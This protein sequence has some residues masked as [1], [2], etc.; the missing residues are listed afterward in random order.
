MRYYL[1]TEFN[2]FK[3]RLLSFA[4]V[5]EDNESIYVINP[6]P[7][8]EAHSITPWVREN[9]IPR[10]DQVPSHIVPQYL[11]YERSA[12]AIEDFLKG[13]ESPEIIVDWPDDIK[14]FSELLI[15]GPGTMIDI[16]RLIYR[17][18]RVD[19]YPSEFPDCVQH[20]AWWDAM[21]LKVKCEVDGLEKR[22]TKRP[23]FPANT[24]HHPSSGA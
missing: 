20:N 14:Y 1:D 4:L 11:D 24:F 13:D 5:R 18:H 19:A 12:W 22:F 7:M 21:A 23:E 3:G 6:T 10:L 16:P 2:S 15:T 17:M 9:V 8:T